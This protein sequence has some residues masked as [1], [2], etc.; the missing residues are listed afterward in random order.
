MLERFAP[1]INP[2]VVIL[3][4]FPND[5][6]SDYIKVIRGEDVSEENYLE[7]FYYMER[8]QSYCSNNN[9]EMIVSLIPCKEQMQ[10]LRKF[11]VFQDRVKA[12][13]KTNEIMILDPLDFF[14]HLGSR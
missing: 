9:I 7:L 1:T 3:N 14:A 10:E 4:L 6:H 2:N 13:C 5:V 8:I 11:T 12:W